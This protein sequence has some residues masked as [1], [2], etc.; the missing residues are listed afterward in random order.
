MIRGK[1]R[2]RIN[3]FT[4]EVDLEGERVRSYLANSGRLPQLII[5]GKEVLLI[6]K[7]KGLP[8]KIL[9]VLERNNW[10]CVDSFLSNRFVWEKL[11]ENVL[12][13][14]EGWKRVRKEVRI[15]DVT[16]DFL[17][18]KEGKW[19]YLEVKTST[20]LHGTISLFPDA[21]TERGR[22]HLEFLKEKAEKGEPSFLLVVTSG[23]N[24]S[25]FAPNYQCDP[26]FTLSFY[27]ALE[28]GVKTYLL[29]V[30]YSPL[31][32]KLFLRKII[33]I[34]IEGVFLAELSIYFSLNGKVEGGKIIIENGKE[35]VKEILEFAEKRGVILKV[36]ENKKGI[37]LHILR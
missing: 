31:Q 20:L 16:L 30:R 23:G 15:G 3:R 21:P 34:S 32:N 37:I 4:V 18:E 8:Y 1:I 7:N 35:K 9:A 10:V 6:K 27:Q 19:G 13:F 29:I 26:A 12:P 2:G 33:P 25:Y 11:K 36:C 14:L 22:R 24:V 17:L 28:K 5:P